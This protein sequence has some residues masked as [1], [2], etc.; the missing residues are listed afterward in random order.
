M[1]RERS[2]DRRRPPEHQLSL[3]AQCSPRPPASISPSELEGKALP[4][5]AFAEETV[6]YGDG[7][8][9]VALGE[10]AEAVDADVL[11]LSSAEVHAHRLDA[12]LLAEFVPCAVLMLP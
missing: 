2:S 3:A 5:V 7:K 12:N 6:P 1:G 10:V 4:E 9:S 11:V 8:T